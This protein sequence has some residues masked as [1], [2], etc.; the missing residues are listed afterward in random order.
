MSGEGDGGESPFDFV[1]AL[2]QDEKL[3]RRLNELETA[4]TCS[5]SNGRAI[6]AKWRVDKADAVKVLEQFAATK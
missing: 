3:L 4:E 2:G 1:F 6:D 5:T